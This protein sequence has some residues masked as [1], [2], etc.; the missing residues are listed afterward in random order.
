L[1]TESPNLFICVN[2]ARLR[3]VLNLF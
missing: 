2:A 3:S 1:L